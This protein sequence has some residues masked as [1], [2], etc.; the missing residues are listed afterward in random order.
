M[1]RCVYRLL[2]CRVHPPA[3][4]GSS[5]PPAWLLPLSPKCLR[6]PAC[7]PLFPQV[8]FIKS[9]EAVYCFL[10]LMIKVLF[11]GQVR[12]ERGS[13]ASAFRVDGVHPRGPHCLRPPR[14][15]ALPARLAAAS[16][17]PNPV[18]L[19]SP[20]PTQDGAVFKWCTGGSPSAAPWRVFGKEG[21]RLVPIGRMTQR[22]TNADLEA[23]L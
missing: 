8:A 5:A 16:Y 2:A 14:L 1:S 4:P 18:L 20:Q 17:T 22:P 10:P 23:I 3:S 21:N 19:P 13:G 12:R 15:P 9:M 6:S 11:I 7:I